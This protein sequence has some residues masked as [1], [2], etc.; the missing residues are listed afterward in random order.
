MSLEYQ[1]VFFS[2]FNVPFTFSYYLEVSSLFYERIY[3]IIFKALFVRDILI[4]LQE[5][6]Y[7]I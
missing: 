1:S 6:L 5:K 2:A 7:D 4:Y 3:V